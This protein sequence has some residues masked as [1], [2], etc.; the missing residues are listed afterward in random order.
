MKGS[1]VFFDVMASLDGFV[2]PEGL[3]MA[4]A[5]DPDYQQWMSK[6]TELTKWVFQQEFFRKNLKIGEGGESGEDNRILKET[7]NRTGVSIMGKRM[8][9]GW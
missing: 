3:E 5:N 7:F 4:H 1:K 8:F 9:D 6:W 2:A